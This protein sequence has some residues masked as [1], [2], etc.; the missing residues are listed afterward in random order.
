MP[1][2]LL[3]RERMTAYFIEAAKHIIEQQGFGALTVRSIAEQAG[4]SYATLYNYFCD[5]EALLGVLVIEYTE[6]CY[7]Y[8]MLHTRE[9]ACKMQKLRTQAMHFVEYYLAKPEVYRL[10]YIEAIYLKQGK[11]LKEKLHASPVIALQK[12]TIQE[13]V[14]AGELNERDADVFGTILRSFL[15]GQLIFYIRGMS[16]ASAESC[17]ECIAAGLDALQQKFAVAEQNTR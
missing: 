3:Q 16:H 5:L 15:H 14:K 10:I 12:H 6:Q 1:N 8:L 9:E 13:C 2:K 17:R 7:E 4:Y 11:A